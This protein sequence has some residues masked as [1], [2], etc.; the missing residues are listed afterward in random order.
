[1][2][3]INVWAVIAAALSSF[4]LGGFWYSPAMFGRIWNREAGRGDNMQHG[5]PALVFGLSF[6]LALIAASVFAVF[7]GSKP[8]LPFAAGAGFAAGLCWVGASF[9]I[10]YLFA[11]RSFK[12]WLIDGSYH[13]AQF[14]LFGMILGLWH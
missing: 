5:H 7:L 9:G 1:M 4:V 8:S 13:T 2:G 3:G 10:N 6:V 12:L 14:T 11:S